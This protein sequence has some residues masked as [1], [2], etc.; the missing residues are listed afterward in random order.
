MTRSMRFLLFLYYS[1]A[2]EETYHAYNFEF[3][4]SRLLFIHHQA[5]CL[6]FNIVL[7]N[8]LKSVNFTEEVIKIFS[9]ELIRKKPFGKKAKL[10]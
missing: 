3:N 10:G 6:S 8:Y 5:V 1:P 7:Q 9:E 4:K 2:A